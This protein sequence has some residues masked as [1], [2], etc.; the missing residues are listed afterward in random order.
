LFRI[1]Q[2]PYIMNSY[3]KK[4][5]APAGLL[6]FIPPEV[7]QPIPKTGTIM[8]DQSR[9]RELL[10]EQ[11][12]GRNAH[13]NFETAVEGLSLENTGNKP[14]G[15]SHTI[16]ELV[17]HIRI[18]QHDI[19]SFSK[20]PHYQSPEWP[21]GYWPESNKPANEEQWKE[22]LQAIKKDQREMESLVK[23]KNNDLLKPLAHGDGQTLFREAMLIVDHNAYH[24][25]QI[26]QMRKAMGNW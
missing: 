18:A 5:S 24:I 11:L 26:V 7:T 12:T 9:V 2:T 21:D 23:D 16:W 19:V 15:F 3:L 6:L 25:G 13:V 1:G 17:E 10:L 8:E 14:D 4:S 22:S 20:D